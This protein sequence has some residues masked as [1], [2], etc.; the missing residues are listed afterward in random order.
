VS[1]KS[2]TAVSVLGMICALPLLAACSATN[3]TTTP[4][5]SSDADGGG[6]GDTTLGGRS[7]TTYSCDSFPAAELLAAIQTVAPATTAGHVVAQAAADEFGSALACQYYFAA[8]LS[9]GHDPSSLE[10]QNVVFIVMLKDKSIHGLPTPQ[11]VRD[12]FARER[13]QAR[14]GAKGDA[15]SDIQSVFL[16]A[17]GLGDDAYFDDY[18]T[19]MSG[20]TANESSDLVVLRGSLPMSLDIVMNYSAL[21]PVPEQTGDPFQNDMRHAM[22]A[23]FAKVVLSKM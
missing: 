11:S 20:V 22:I 21:P 17:S 15:T 18:Y 16:P 3:A 8:N 1:I 7:A 12:E 5:G 10:G 2:F 9:A 19:R 13:E 6:G 14:S 23:A 4:G